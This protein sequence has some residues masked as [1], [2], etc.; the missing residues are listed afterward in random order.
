MNQD[1]FETLLVSLASVYAE[2][3]EEEIEALANEAS[4]ERLRDGS[5]HQ[6]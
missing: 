1:E 3:Y 2:A 4:R 5:G 6:E